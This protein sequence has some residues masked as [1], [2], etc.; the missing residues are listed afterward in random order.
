MV[1]MKANLTMNMLPIFGTPKLAQEALFSKDM[2]RDKVKRYCS[3]LEGESYRAYL[4]MLGLNL[5]RPDRVRTPILVMGAA[6][7]CLIPPRDVEA[8]ASA[9][10]TKAEV[11]PGYGTR[12]DIRGGMANG[13][14]SDAELA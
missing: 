1:F 8:T 2:P 4:D 7:D 6:E 13:S 9:Y 12:H 5:P 10:Q 14:G 3:L 11:L